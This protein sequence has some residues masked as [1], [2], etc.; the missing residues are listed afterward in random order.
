M[1]IELLMLIIGL[2]AVQ[3]VLMLTHARAHDSQQGFHSHACCAQM[4]VLAAPCPHGSLG[5]RS[6][7]ELQNCRVMS[8]RWHAGR[9]I[10]R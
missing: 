1:C 9:C 8:T 7:M 3:A 2:N 5:N 4:A 6:C 10:E